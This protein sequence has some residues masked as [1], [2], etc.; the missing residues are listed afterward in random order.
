E[1][2]IKLAKMIRKPMWEWHIYIGYVLVGLYAVRLF[3]PFFGQMKFANPQK[4]DL[5]LKTKF[6]YWSY[7]VFYVCTGI[8][9]ITGLVI[10]FGPKEWKQQ[11][12]EIH[13]LSIYYLLAFIF[14]H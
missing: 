7:L 1:Q 3:L 12:E 14:I 2:S 6:Q 5:A 4:K 13:E 9:L 8:S 10:E 11:T